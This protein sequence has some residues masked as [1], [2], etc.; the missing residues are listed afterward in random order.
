MKIL[1]TIML[2]PMHEHVYEC[3]QAGL[4]TL[5]GMDNDLESDAQSVLSK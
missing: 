5:D 4:T 2:N 1:F 3:I